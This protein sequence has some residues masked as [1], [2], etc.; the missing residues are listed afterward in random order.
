[1][2]NDVVYSITLIDGEIISLFDRYSYRSQF[3]DVNTEVQSI[4]L[5]Y[6]NGICRLNDQDN[7]T[8]MIIPVRRIEK[9]HTVQ[10]LQRK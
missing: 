5:D 6:Q 9:I 2:K 8:L 1:M 4:E 3:T 7:K 10:H